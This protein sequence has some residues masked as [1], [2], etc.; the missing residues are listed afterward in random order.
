MV[1]LEPETFMVQCMINLQSTSIMA[2][3]DQTDLV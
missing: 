2:E 1:S 3:Y